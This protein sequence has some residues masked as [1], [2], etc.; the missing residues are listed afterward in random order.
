MYLQQINAVI[1]E[2]ERLKLANHEQEKQR[3]QR[4]HD[5][6]KAALV[7]ENEKEVFDQLVKNKLELEALQKDIERLEKAFA[8]EQQLMKEEQTKLQQG[9]NLVDMRE[10]ENVPIPTY[11]LEKM[12]KLQR[13]DDGVFTLE[14]VPDVSDRQL[15]HVLRLLRDKPRYAG[16]VPVRL[17]AL[18]VIHC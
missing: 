15:E 13:N 3:K 10:F 2:R 5:A 14:H 17:K 1:I 12:T 16:I 11:L 6:A 8:R 7:A 18:R 9:V 4:R